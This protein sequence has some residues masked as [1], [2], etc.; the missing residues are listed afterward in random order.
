MTKDETRG[1]RTVRTDDPGDDGETRG[2]VLVAL[3]ANLLIALA[4]IAGGLVAASPALLSEAAHSVATASGDIA[5]D[6]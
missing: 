3:L 6:E 1:A 2:T 5:S 4:K